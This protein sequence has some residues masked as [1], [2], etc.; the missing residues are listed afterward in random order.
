[1]IYV[2]VEFVDHYNDRRRE[3]IA[4]VPYE[5]TDSDSIAY[6]GGLTQEFDDWVED[7][8]GPDW[9]EE[10]KEEYYESCEWF[11]WFLD[12]DE[13]EEIRNKE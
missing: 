1:M 8:V 3:F 5:E 12:E 9:V 11:W 13:V 10:E 2:G 4:L 6:D 7:G